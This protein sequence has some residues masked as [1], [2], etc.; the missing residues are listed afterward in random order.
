[1]AEASA[2]AAPD[3]S[4]PPVAA[5]PALLLSR[6]TIE[7]ALMARLRCAVHR[8]VWVNCD[9]ESSDEI[10]VRSIWWIRV[11]GTPRY[12]CC[13]SEPP[14]GYPQWPV[15]YLIGAY[16]RA[17]GGGAG[18]LLSCSSLPVLCPASYRP[19]A[20][21]VTPLRSLPDCPTPPCPAVTA[22]EGRNV[23]LLKEAQQQQQLAET[24][25]VGG[26]GR[27]VSFDGFRGSCS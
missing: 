23:G 9:Q 10:R 27:G 15:H 2:A 19:F 26:T 21:T 25:R 13:C 20:V 11:R 14:A 24:L 22:E 6:D 4:D 12:C 16:A 18:W 3:G 1:M 5:T 17:A 7:R 8:C